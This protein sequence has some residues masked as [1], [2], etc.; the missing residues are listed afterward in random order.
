MVTHDPQHGPDTFTSQGDCDLEQ[1]RDEWTEFCSRLGIIRTPPIYLATDLP[2][3]C[4][5]GL[6][7]YGTPKDRLGAAGR[8]PADD[9]VVISGEA[10]P[11]G[12]ALHV[13]PDLLSE[14]VVP[15]EVRRYVLAHHAAHLACGHY[16]DNDYSTWS[17]LL[18]AFLKFACV[19]LC[20][21]A[22]V[23]ALADR[24]WDYLMLAAGAG[25]WLLKALIIGCA[26]AWSRDTETTAD[27][28]AGVAL[29]QPLTPELV[30]WFH[31][32]PTGG[33]RAWWWA[34]APG[35]DTRDWEARAGAAELH[36]HLTRGGGAR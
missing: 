32:R 30:E 14:A 35:I 9:L 16:Q 25:C 23:G 11:D 33:L 15:A 31:P 29:G 20:I 27:L 6:A 36:Q 10:S 18:P 17:R 34:T 26:A 19:A 5:P 8:K 1:V 28:L 7:A 13:S 24:P 4:Q 12:L 3:D 2:E 22:V 21:V